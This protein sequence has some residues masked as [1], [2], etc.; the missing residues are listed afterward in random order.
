VGGGI[1]EGLRQPGGNI[2]GISKP[3]SSYLAKRTEY[4]LQME[5][6]I[7]RLGIYYDPDYP[8][9]TS[10]VPAVAQA[11]S[12]LN[13][14]LIEIP[15]KSPEEVIADLEGR[16]GSEDPGLDAIQ[17]MP[18]PINNNSAEAFV[19]FANEH[20]LPIAAHTPGQVNDGALFS[21][22][23]SNAKA[24]EMAAPLADKILKGT[25]PGDLSIE[26][27]DLFLTLNLQAAEAIGLDLPDTIIRQADTIIRE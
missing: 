9:A 20:K 27:T 18:D 7:K 24:G 1:V 17:M 14:E 5:P 16:S 4:L 2:T 10:S 3:D 13:I 21:F 19:N 11:A 8:T 6:D 25:K 26:T 15:V 23:D 12:A 22:A